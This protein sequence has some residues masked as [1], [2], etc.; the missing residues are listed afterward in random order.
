M[1]MLPLSRGRVALVDDDVFAWASRFRWC[2]LGVSGHHYV[3][4][5]LVTGKRGCPKVYLHREIMGAAETELVDHVDRNTFDNRRGNLRVCNHSGNAANS[6]KVS[7]HGGRPT[8][9]S[10]K[11]VTYRRSSGRWLAQIQ[12][13]DRYSYLGSFSSEEDAARAYDDAA[14]LNFGEFA[15]TNFPPLVAVG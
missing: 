14:R 9:S 15:R 1:K 4:R 8:S 3:Y 10:F 6:A 2:V 5:N 11:G 12:K 13:G 7:H